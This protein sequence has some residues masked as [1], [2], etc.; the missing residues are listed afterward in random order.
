MTLS[1][2][3]LSEKINSTTRLYVT[4]Q[5]VLGGLIG[6]IHGIAEILQGNHPT[7][8]FLLNSI[9]AFTLIPNYLATGIVAVFI[10]LCLLT[11]TIGFIHTKYGAIVFLLI[12]AAL[13]LA[14]GGVAQV[15]F[16]L[17]AW[18]VG[19]QIHQ[20]LTWWRATIPELLRK[21]LAKNW[22]SNFAAGYFFLLLGITIWLVFTPPGSV[23]KDPLMQYIC[24]ASLAIGF[25]FQLLTIV[26]GF[27]L[28]IERQTV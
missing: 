11:W 23:Y 2:P 8:G 28:D 21:R 15:G 17:I 1:K 4:I 7:K 9:G 3:V 6:M 18:G 19:T 12:S 20:R 22:R 25:V 13:F 5:G 27:A 10:G 24:W 16:F 14:G 26:S